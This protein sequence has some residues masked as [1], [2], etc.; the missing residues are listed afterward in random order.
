MPPWVIGI[1]DWTWK[2]GHRYGTVICDLERRQI[3]DLLPDRAASTVD[4]WLL[5]RPGIEIIARN[6]GGG[7]GHA[8]SRAAPHARQSHFTAERV[9][10]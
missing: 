5:A 2:R 8:T 3:I 1:D 6:R 10:L 4:A 9:D 7:Y